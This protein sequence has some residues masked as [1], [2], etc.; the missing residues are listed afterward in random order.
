[1]TM[2]M[3]ESLLAEPAA[4]DDGP[5]LDRPVKKPRIAY[6]GRSRQSGI[7]SKQE[8][9]SSSNVPSSPLGRPGVEDVSDSDEN[10]FD[11]E[12]VN[13][14]AS[15]ELNDDSMDGI[16]D[17]NIS[18]GP[19]SFDSK[20]KK[21]VRSRPKGEFA[22]NKSHWL[23]VHKLHI[24]CLLGHC[25]FVN[26]RCSNSNV[27]QNLRNG[28][29]TE[30]VMS[31]LHPSSDFS[32]SRRDASFM[33][34][35]SKLHHE[36]KGRF[37]IS[38]SGLCRPWWV[39]EGT[40]PRDQDIGDAVDRDDFVRASK[41]LTG[42]QD[43]GNQLF[44]A[45]LRAAHVKAR[46]VC[47]LQPLPFTGV[48]S[49]SIPQKP[50]KEPA[51]TVSPDYGRHNRETSANNTSRTATA[52][53]GT[54]QATRRR[55][56]N[57]GFASNSHQ[58]SAPVQKRFRK[59]DYPVF[60]VEAFNEARQSWIPADPMVTWTV[61][62]P[63]KIQ[64][65]QIYKWNQLTYVIAF[66]ASGVARDVTRRYTNAYNAKTRRHRI[67]ATG[68]EG[69]RWWET[70]MK[71]F[72][73][74]NGPND[75]DRIEDAELL[76]K[77]ER[78]PMPRRIIDFKDHPHFVLERHLKMD[79]VIYPL[80]DNGNKTL[81]RVNAGT[82]AKP[83]MET[84]YRRGD[85]Q[86]CYSADVWFR[87]GRQVKQG[88]QPVKHRSRKIANQAA[89]DSGD[90]DGVKTHTIALYA[91]SQTEL[92][93]P[94]PV[95]HGRVPRNKYGNIYVYVPS[96][97]PAGGRHIQNDLARQ[98]ASLLQVDCVDAIV[99]FKFKGRGTP[100]SPIVNGV[101]VADKYAEAVCAV[102]Q[103]FQEEMLEEQ[104]RARSF[105]ALHSWKHFHLALK[106][107]N[108]VS[109]YG[110]G[111]AI[112]GEDSVMLGQDLE[113]DAEVPAMGSI[114]GATDN[115]PLSTAGQFYL[116][117]LRKKPKKRPPRKARSMSDDEDMDIGYV[118]TS[119][120]DGNAQY[121]SQSGQSPATYGGGGFVVEDEGDGSSLFN[122][123]STH[124]HEDASVL[125][126]V[127]SP[128]N[129]HDDVADPE[130]ESV[131]GPD[132][133]Y[134]GGFLPE[135]SNLDA[136]ELEDSYGG[137]FLPEH[138]DMDEN[139]AKDD[140]TM[141]SALPMVSED[142]NDGNNDSLNALRAGENSGLGEAAMEQPER[143][144]DV[145]PS[146]GASEDV[147]VDGNT[148]D[149]TVGST[150]LPEDNTAK[151]DDL[152]TMNDSGSMQSQDPEDEDMDPDWLES[153]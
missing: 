148:F 61:N 29:L 51:I 150:D 63:A 122:G 103:G 38:A 121:E 1:M 3:Y 123:S 114:L 52:N 151:R 12:D 34:G 26:G 41:D 43:L 96:M 14:D 11:F 69:Q 116:D 107:K 28:L 106:I 142:S 32:Q 119:D 139:D 135:D 132:D 62:K 49:P 6:A 92:Y 27:H 71:L 111:S 79:Q 16:E 133:P 130:D 65:P 60:W 120:S 94:P 145:G 5:E 57:P 9:V 147:D 54:T 59:L 21:L 83:K 118:T 105:A 30:D 86:A 23:L 87:R 77:D 15:A 108:R 40:K 89:N 102:I 55:L 125:S 115:D 80:R 149:A 8:R 37:R 66:E 22:G 2:D 78:E 70:T 39:L 144:D 76:R 56:A 93:V 152:G 68:D 104:H 47:S 127:S 81:P 146:A 124:D 4:R 17:L 67:E 19:A 91:T 24:L 153:D 48:S 31:R 90:T 10:D 129:E 74:R 73:R 109:Q 88:E 126:N 117:E 35:L 53:G 42:S 72:R 50:T 97:V 136:D 143:K 33:D 110:D 64:P 45:L 140:G 100:A 75:R 25:I 98:A 99:G 44:C 7:T 138:G 58:A 112:Q 20:A 84:V 13:L 137:G 46:V 85:V 82:A 101:V 134:G 113:Q 95:E 128:Y 36:F 131:H 141:N 18:V